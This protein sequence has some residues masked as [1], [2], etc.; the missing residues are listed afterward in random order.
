VT[1]LPTVQ[2]LSGGADLATAPYVPGVRDALLQALFASSSSLSI[3]VFQDLFGWTDRINV[4]STVADHNW[5][6]RLPWP[7]DRL[8]AVP[9]ARERQAALLAWSRQFERV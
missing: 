6:F 7:V 5:T 2:R 4:P 1:G 9:E 8:D 3:S